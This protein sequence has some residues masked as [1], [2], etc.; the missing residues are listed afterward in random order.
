MRYTSIMAFGKK[1]IYFI[2]HAESALNAGGVRQGREGKLTERGREQA[3]LL[4]KRLKDAGVECILTSPYERTMET[5]AILSSL[6]EVPVEASELLVERRNPTEIIGRR[7]DEL[8]VRRAIDFIDKTIHPDTARY[9]DEE[10][11]AEIKERGQELLRM[12]AA[13]RE[14]NIMV[15]SHALFITVLA[16]LIVV[17]DGLTAAELAKLRYFN[18]PGEEKKDTSI[19][20]QNT[21][22]TLAEYRSFSL[23]KEKRGWQLLLWNDA[24]HLGPGF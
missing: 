13:R 5:A 15:V 3:Q 16:S 7:K 22:L 14:K 23:S 21:A 4:A 9:S 24:S 18:A 8:E 20:V 12:L 2:R 11:F 1:Y 10:T 6:L 17:G 19:I